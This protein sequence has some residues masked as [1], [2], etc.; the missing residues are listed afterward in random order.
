MLIIERVK[1]LLVVCATLFLTHKVVRATIQSKVA[2]ATMFRVQKLY[3]KE[4]ND[5]FTKYTRLRWKKRK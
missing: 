4:I 5:E 2:R 1:N 3:K